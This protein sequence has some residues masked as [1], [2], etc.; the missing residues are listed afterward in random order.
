ML[1][2][3]D[4]RLGHQDFV[5]LR[6]NCIACPFDLVSG[7]VGDVTPHSKVPTKRIVCGFCDSTSPTNPLPSADC[8]TIK[9]APRKIE[10][11]VARTAVG[12]ELDDWFP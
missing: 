3:C 7:R 6:P 9:S 5:P 8:Q 12:E 2:R 11:V 4:L 1:I 10:I